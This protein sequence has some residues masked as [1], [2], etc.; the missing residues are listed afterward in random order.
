MVAAPPLSLTSP[1]TPQLPEPTATAF[2][3]HHRLW[4][5]LLGKRKDEA[6]AD[7]SIAD[8]LGA[9]FTI[10]RDAALF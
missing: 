3:P 6:L 1:P 9:A 8:G 10:N 2:L 5:G 4:R 7:Q